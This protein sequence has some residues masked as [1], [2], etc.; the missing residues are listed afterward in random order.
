MVTHVACGRGVEA[1]CV[2]LVY[3]FGFSK[4][5]A[6]QRLMLT[7]ME[8]LRADPQWDTASKVYI[9]GRWS[10]QMSVKQN[11]CGA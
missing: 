1:E 4:T 11:I 8:T 9:H 7:I 6:T 3:G 2:C 5:G 10:D